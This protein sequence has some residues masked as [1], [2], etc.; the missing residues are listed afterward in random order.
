MWVGEKY[1]ELACPASFNK[2][3]WIDAILTTVSIYCFSGSIMPSTLAYYENLRH[4]Q[5]AETA[6]NPAN[7]ITVPFGFTSYFYDSQPSTKKTVERTANLVF[8][9]GS[10]CAKSVSVIR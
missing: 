5:F 10:C 8:Y 6:T 1:H 2:P 3:S 4:H 9:R 7:R